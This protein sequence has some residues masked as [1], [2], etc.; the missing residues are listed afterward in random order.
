MVEPL[1]ILELF[2]ELFR[3][4][5]KT[6]RKFLYAY[7]VN[8]IKTVNSKHKDHKLYFESLTT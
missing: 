8:D 1:V 6:L 2:F 7:V 3:C 4:Q 5:D